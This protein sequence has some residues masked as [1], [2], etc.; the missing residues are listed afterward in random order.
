MRCDGQLAHRSVHRGTTGLGI[1][2]HRVSDMHVAGES[3]SSIVLEKLPNKAKPGQP[4]QPGIKGQPVQAA[5]AQTEDIN[6]KRAT[7]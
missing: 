3:D 4:G 6:E 1:E 7:V 5:S 2:L